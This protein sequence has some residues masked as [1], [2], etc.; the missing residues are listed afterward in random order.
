MEIVISL[1]P[2]LENKPSTP[3]SP[4]RLRLIKILFFFYLEGLFDHVFLTTR[5]RFER[6]NSSKEKH[7]WVKDRF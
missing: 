3:K 5:D 1:I 2:F 7:A 4:R 6:N